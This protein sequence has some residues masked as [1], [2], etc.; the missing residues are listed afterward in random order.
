[1]VRVKLINW[2]VGR[3]WVTK[4]NTELNIDIQKQNIYTYT[5]VRW[6]VN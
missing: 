1:M 2:K 4:E 3:R 5:L 6:Y